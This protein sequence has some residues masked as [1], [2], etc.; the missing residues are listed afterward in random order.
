MPPGNAAE[1]QAVHAQVCS[2]W[3][4]AALAYDSQ[5]NH[6]ENTARGWC[7]DMS[8]CE[9]MCSHCWQRWGR[10]T[11][12]LG[13]QLAC[14]QAH[15]RHHMTELGQEL[16]KDTG[17]HTAMGRG[18]DTAQYAHPCYCVVLGWDM[19]N[20]VALEHSPAE[21]GMAMLLYVPRSCCVC[22]QA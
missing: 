1:T 5:V 20:V 9:H 14:E 18:W 3:R 13:M 12:N 17:A 21:A 2:H 19:A 8:Q 7:S 6:P 4:R 10:G 16:F 22:K 11:H 15:P